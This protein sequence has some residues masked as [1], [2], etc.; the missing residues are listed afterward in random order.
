MPIQ[1]EL[2]LVNSGADAVHVGAWEGQTNTANW[3]ISDIQCKCDLLTLDNALDNEYASHPLSGKPLPINFSTWNRTNQSTGNDK[4]FSANINRALTRL[5]PV[6]I[7]LQGAEG[8][9]DKQCNG[10]HH[11]TAMNAT[12]TY[13]VSDEH[14]YQVQI[15]S[16]LIPEYPVKSFSESLSQLGKTV[17]GNFQMFGRWYRTRKY[18]IGLD[19]EKASGAG[20]IGMSTKP[21]DLMTL[22]FRDCEVPGLGGSTPQRVLCALN[23]DCP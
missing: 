11:P 5:K 1:I 17:G 18:I 6:F 19:L 22:N 2:E 16:K 13:S 3:S 14:Q 12:D 8:V 23:Y 4:Y 10:F 21:G 20:F 9:W 15:G 7:T